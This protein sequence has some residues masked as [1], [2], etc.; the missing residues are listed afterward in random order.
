VPELRY[1][2]ASTQRVHDRW[3]DVSVALNSREREQLAVQLRDRVAR[4]HWSDARLS[5]VLAA[6]KAVFD[7]ERREREDLEQV[8]AFLCEEIRASRS[9]TFLAGMLSAH[10]ESF[11]AGANHTRALAQALDA[12]R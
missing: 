2:R 8:R 1:I 6:A 5:F 3:P 10:L 4:N 11:E 7:T 9:E 12:A